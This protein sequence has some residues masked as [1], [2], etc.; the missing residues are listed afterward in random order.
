MTRCLNYPLFTNPHNYNR[1][2]H[3]DISDWTVLSENRYSLDYT[4]YEHDIGGEW[5]VSI[6]QIYDVVGNALSKQFTPDQSPYKFSVT[7]LDPDTTPPTV[8]GITFEPSTVEAGNTVSIIVNAQDDN[9]GLDVLQV[10]IANAEGGQ[11]ETIGAPISGWTALDNNQYSREHTINQYALGGEWHVSSVHF[12][13]V[14][15][16]ILSV[17]Y[18]ADES[19][20][21][22][23]VT[24]INPDTTLPTLGDITFEPTSASAGDTVSVIVEAEDDIL[25]VGYILVNISNPENTNVRGVASRIEFWEALEDN[26]YSRTFVLDE[27]AMSGSW[28]VSNI[29][30][31]DNANNYLSIYHNS[32]SSPDKL[33]V[34]ET[35]SIENH[36]QQKL[37]VYPN[38]LESFIHIDTDFSIAKIYDLHGR[39]QQTFHTKTADVSALEKGIYIL[40]LYNAKLMMMATFKFIKK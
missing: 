3:G 22:F 25:G 30:I 23:S 13:D 28:F 40:E 14:L 33:E 15:G 27:S 5:Y 24:A 8:D 38:P 4:I 11:L 26:R 34:G 35:A 6:V 2:V 21:K 12:T 1:V 32:D 7:A 17:F 36:Q 29:H 16:N 19:P 37:T 20:S 10:N 31:T 9:S 39:L 18:P